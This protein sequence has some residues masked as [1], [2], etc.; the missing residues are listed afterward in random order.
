MLRYVHIIVVHHL[1][2]IR[3][4]ILFYFKF[5]FQIFFLVNLINPISL[6][7]FIFATLIQLNNFEH[8]TDSHLMQKYE[9][10]L[11]LIDPR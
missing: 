2:Y 6:I 8:L 7:L 9:D 11:I 3:K 10:L 1:F 5:I 4:G